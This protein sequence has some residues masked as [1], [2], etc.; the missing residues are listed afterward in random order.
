MLPSA[1]MFPNTVSVY[2][3]E[4]VVAK[5]DSGA[6]TR[7]MEAVAAL[8]DV[9]CSVQRGGSRVVYEWG[10]RHLVESYNVFFRGAVAVLRGDE[11]R[12]SDG[13]VFEVEGLGDEAGRG[14]VSEVTCK[15]VH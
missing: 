13:R 11:L 8:A 10:Q 5:D 4:V 3:P 6:P 2:R 12:A 9:A 1:K 14:V 7:E 15:L